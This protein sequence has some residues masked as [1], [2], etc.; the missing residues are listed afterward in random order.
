MHMILTKQCP[1]YMMELMSLTVLRD[2]DLDQQMVEL[3][4]S[5]RFELNSASELSATLVL[6]LGT[7]YRTIYILTITLLALSDN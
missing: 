3:S 2:L 7:L 5:R 4:I 1:D 6:L